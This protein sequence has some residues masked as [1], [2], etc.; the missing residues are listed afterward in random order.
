MLKHLLQVLSTTLV[1]FT[2][3]WGNPLASAQNRA[4]FGKV[5]LFATSITATPPGFNTRY[6]SLIALSMCFK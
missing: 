3:L 1:L 2:S 4:I 6:S 5:R